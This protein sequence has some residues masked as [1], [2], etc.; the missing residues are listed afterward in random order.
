MLKLAEP[1]KNLEIYPNITTNKFQKLRYSNTKIQSENETKQTSLTQSYHR[2]SKPFW[3]V[4]KSARK[5]L[6]RYEY[7]NLKPTQVWISA[8]TCQ[9]GETLIRRCTERI[10][11][12][13]ASHL[14]GYTSTTKTHEAYF[15]N[16]NGIADLIRGFHRHNTRQKLGREGG[17]VSNTFNA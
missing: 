6:R 12:S 9:N 3:L 4:S 11:V 2:G 16:Q 7:T 10:P 14:L 8:K 13:W 15:E 1:K 17:S 5:N